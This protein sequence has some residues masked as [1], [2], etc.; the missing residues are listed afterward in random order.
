MVHASLTRSSHLSSS[1]CPAQ[2]VSG[3]S[4]D[5]I[6]HVVNFLPSAAISHLLRMTLFHFLWLH[7]LMVQLPQYHHLWSR[8][9]YIPSSHVSWLLH[10]CATS[11]FQIPVKEW[12]VHWIWRLIPMLP[13]VLNNYFLKF[14]LHIKIRLHVLIEKLMLVFILSL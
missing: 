11:F 8:A 13:Y 10:R 4:R 5:T 1:S 7:L 9:Q 2:Q 14:Y 6:I 3:H 12:W